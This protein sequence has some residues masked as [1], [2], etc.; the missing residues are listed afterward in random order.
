MWSF[1]YGANING[2]GMYVTEA[3]V[4]VNKVY[5]FLSE[6]VDVQATAFHPVST[7]D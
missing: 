5:A 6:H 4:V 3:G 7:R 1:K 2:T